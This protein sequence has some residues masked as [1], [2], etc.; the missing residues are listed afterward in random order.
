M[1]DFIKNVMGGGKANEPAAVQH[2]SGKS[3]HLSL[4]D[5]PYLVATMSFLRY[6]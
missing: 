6:N 5:D 2:D 3:R 1:S 4:Y